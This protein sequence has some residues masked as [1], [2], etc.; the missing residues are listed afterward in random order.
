MSCLI[1]PYVFAAGG[2][3]GFDFT[4]M[5]WRVRGD[6]I[7]LA[8]EAGLDTVAWQDMTANNFDWTF[9]DCTYKT[10]EINGHA[11][12]FF[13]GNSTNDHATGPNLSGAGLTE[14]DVF[15]VLI[16]NADPAVTGPYGLWTFN[17]A[18]YV[19]AHTQYPDGS[20][21]IHMTAFLPSGQARLTVNPT[22]SVAVWHLLRVVA[23]TGSSNYEIF[24]DGTSIATG[25]RTSLVFPAV[26]VLAQAS[27]SGGTAGWWGMVAEFFA[28]ST[29]CDSTQTG[30]IR[31]YVNSYYGL[32]VV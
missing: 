3:T 10:N 17:D 12:V 25:T 24:I 11:A 31:D 7:G 8:D 23:K 9:N 13:G 15:A 18:D 27:D 29:K 21:N 20:G 2:V 6:E 26:T 32:S 28:F 30:T 5:L 1:N 4:N 19:N 22:P 16:A 14:I